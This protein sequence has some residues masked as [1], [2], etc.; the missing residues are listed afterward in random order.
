MY[1]RKCGQPLKENAKFCMK[2]GCA[3]TQNYV[4]N[5]TARTTKPT[6]SRTEYF[7]NHCTSQ[8]QKWIKSVKIWLIAYNVMAY[9]GAIFA[10]YVL[11]GFFNGNVFGITDL[12]KFGVREKEMITLVLVCGAILLVITTFLGLVV[13]YTKRVGAAVGFLIMTYFGGTAIATGF[14]PVCIVVS[15]VILVY[16]VKMNKEYKKMAK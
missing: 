10:F 12:P 16:I 8:C 11:Y 6:M 5:R 14:W 7:E 3:V 15:I 9:V 13:Y 1:C 2:C 4:E